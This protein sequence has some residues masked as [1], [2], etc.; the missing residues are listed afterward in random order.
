MRKRSE[1]REEAKRLRKLLERL[2]SPGVMVFVEG[3]RDVE[4]LREAGVNAFPLKG[5]HPQPK[6]TV[7][8]LTDLD[9][10][11]ERLAKVYSE[12]WAPMPGVDSVDTRTRKELAGLLHISSFEGFSKALRRKKE[13]LKG[14]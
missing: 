12:Q 2:K 3:R 8:L 11:G 10:E 14:V 13:E 5:K 6:G 4:S 9:S 1:L 7:I